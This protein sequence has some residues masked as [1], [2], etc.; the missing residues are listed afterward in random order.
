MA[1]ATKFAPG[2]IAILHGITN[3]PEVNGREITIVCS[4]DHYLGEMWYDIEAP[5]LPTHPDRLWLVAE[6]RLRKRPAPPDWNAIA[7]CDEKVTCA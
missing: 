1:T 3:M 7:Y 5:W 4:L 6:C 2:E